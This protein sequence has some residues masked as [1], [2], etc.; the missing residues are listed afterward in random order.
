METIFLSSIFLQNDR[1]IKKR[2]NHS[3]KFD[4]LFGSPAQKLTSYNLP[5]TGLQLAPKRWR[6]KLA[7][8]PIG[9]M[10]YE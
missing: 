7:G 10:Q 8:F 4:F 3:K 6:L 9:T 1:S 2:K 5:T